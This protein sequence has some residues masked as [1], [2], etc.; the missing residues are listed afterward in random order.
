MNTNTKKVI[1]K[2]NSLRINDIDDFVFHVKENANTL[3]ISNL[4]SDTYQRIARINTSVI[5]LLVDL[6]T[7]ADKSNFY[8]TSFGTL[9]RY[10]RAIIGK[11]KFIDASKL[12][13]I[14]NDDMFI[15]ELYLQ[16]LGRKVDQEAKNHLSFM[17]INDHSYRI[18]SI[19][20]VQY[21]E[22]IER[23]NNYI[24]GIW[25]LKMGLTL[26]Q[27]FKRIVNR[28]TRGIR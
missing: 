22:E 18:Q 12:I 21:S 5:K 26:S 13:A 1:T 8:K 14:N 16:A 20:N 7:K 25:S 19:F 10:C 6:N 24:S 17:L 9:V 23:T 27:F 15:T 11:K 4:S 3:S 2:L 28:L